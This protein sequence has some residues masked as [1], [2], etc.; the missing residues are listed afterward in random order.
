M[1]IVSIAISK[2]KGTRKTRIEE[3]R[4]IEGYG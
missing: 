4:L 3:A 2:K 1:R